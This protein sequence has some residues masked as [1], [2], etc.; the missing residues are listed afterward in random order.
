MISQPIS[1]L[2]VVWLTIISNAKN[3]V[4]GEKA[5]TMQIV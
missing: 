2:S 5:P 1:S 4:L 3:S